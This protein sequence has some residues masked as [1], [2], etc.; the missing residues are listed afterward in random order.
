MEKLWSQGNN[1]RK[2]I[3]EK[4][5]RYSVP[6]PEDAKS[7]GLQIAFRGLKSQR[8]EFFARNSRENIGL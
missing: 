6:G 3:E 7:Q 8:H 2:E 1:R 4:S 5:E